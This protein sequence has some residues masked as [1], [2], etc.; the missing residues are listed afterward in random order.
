MKIAI[1]HTGRIYSSYWIKYCDENHIDYKIVNAY[2][3]DIINQVED[4]DIFMWHYSQDS[5][6]DMNFAKQLLFVLS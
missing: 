5:A 4:C 6:V 1:H 2:A 3:N